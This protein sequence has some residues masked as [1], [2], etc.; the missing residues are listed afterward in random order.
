MTEKRENPS[1]AA[2]LSEL[3]VECYSGYRASQRPLRFTLRGRVFE[4]EEVDDQWYEPSAI[5]FR[6]RASDGNFYVLRHDEI[7]DTWTLTA[8]RAGGR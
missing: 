2:A 4:V 3:Q 5:Y 6:V 1:G 8:F 7:A